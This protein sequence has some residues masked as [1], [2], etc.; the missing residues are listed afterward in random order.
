MFNLI[1][2]GIYLILNIAVHGDP[3]S[4]QPHHL[5]SLAEGVNRGL[6]QLRVERAAAKIHISLL[7]LKIKRPNYPQLIPLNGYR[8]RG[9]IFVV[10]LG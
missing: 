7:T 8:I 3:G 9:Y 5:Q 6:H 2:F 10:N 4:R 1:R